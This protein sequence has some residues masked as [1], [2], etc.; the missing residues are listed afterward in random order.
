MGYPRGKEETSVHRAVGD[1]HLATVQDVGVSL[2]Y[3]VCAHRHHVRAAVRFGHADAADLVSGTHRGEEA[4]ALLV[5]GVDVDVVYK[6]NGVSWKEKM[7]NGVP[8]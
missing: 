5:G 6:Q 7:G 4:A 2:L 1:P 8:R 3:G